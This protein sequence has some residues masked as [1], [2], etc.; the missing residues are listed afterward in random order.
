[1]NK[2]FKNI[3]EAK[4]SFIFTSIFY[5][6]SQLTKSINYRLNYNNNRLDL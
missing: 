4:Q 2:N 6:Y 3:I 5:F 1:M